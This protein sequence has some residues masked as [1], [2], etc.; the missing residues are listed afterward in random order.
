MNNRDAELL[1]MI[2][3]RWDAERAA[4]IPHNNYFQLKCPHCQYTTELVDEG[5][6]DTW[7]VCSCCGCHRMFDRDDLESMIL[8]PLRRIPTKEVRPIQD[9]DAI[10]VDTRITLSGL[11]APA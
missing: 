3:S 10:P 8:E 4:E 7:T 9:R 5:G 2:H 11:L 6:A 1:K